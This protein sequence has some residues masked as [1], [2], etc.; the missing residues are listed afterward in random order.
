M[1][2]VSAALKDMERVD[3]RGFRVGF[4]VSY[5][6]VNRDNWKKFGKLQS[7]LDGL[8]KGSAEYKQVKSKI[9][10]LDIGGKVVVINK[11]TM[12][13]RNKSPNGEVIKDADQKH[14]LIKDPRHW[15]NRTRNFRLSNG[16]TRKCRI[17]LI[18][19]YNNETVIF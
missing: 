5:L 1:I 7:Q 18:M 2:T 15:Q 16:E 12:T 6:T 14:Q 17:R 8:K 9:D 19:E 3:N 11:C 4:S 10:L 13:G